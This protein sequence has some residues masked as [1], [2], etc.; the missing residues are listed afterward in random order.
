MSTTR[1]LKAILPVVALT[2]S[3]A[4]SAES[5][6]YV[7]GGFNSTTLEQ[8]TTRNTGTN[9]PNMGP[10]GGAS[11]STS[12]RDTGAS[13]YIAGGYEFSPF[14][15]SFVAVEAYYA[16]ENAET[17]NIN[18]VKVTDLTLNSSYGVDLKLGHSV[19][20]KFAVYGLLG[21]AQY[22]FDGTI[23]YTFAP[24]VDDI[25]S[26]EAGFVYGGGVEIKFN[27][28]WSTVA[29]VRLINDLDLSTP[30]DRGAIQSSDDLEFT[31][32][33]SGLKYKF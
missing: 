7:Q 22:D 5:G 14:P 9:G 21:I 18:N 3:G 15:D 10:A 11:A 8:A 17:Q 23:T 13:I 33:R 25:S 20:D 6:W 29:E 4:A 2:I 28:N 30:I 31:I 16:D 26:E 27:D 19:T 1:F 12:D 32:I 24:P